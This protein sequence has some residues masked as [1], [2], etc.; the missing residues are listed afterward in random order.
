MR[1]AYTSRCEDG[2]KKIWYP[3]NLARE[4]AARRFFRVTEACS[5]RNSNHCR[6]VEIRTVR[7]VFENRSFPIVSKFESSRRR[8]LA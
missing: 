3:P 2:S 4:D 6:H 1:L 5:F 7:I 8:F